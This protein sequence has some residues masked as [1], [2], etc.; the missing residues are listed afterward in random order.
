[1]VLPDC[2]FDL[3]SPLVIDAS[4]VINLNATGCAAQILAAIPNRIVVTD[5]VA[6][7]LEAGR[8]KGRTDAEQLAILVGSSHVDR[9]PLSPAAEEHFLNLVVGDGVATLDDG[10][11][12]TIAWAVSQSGIPVI[13]DK[14]AV[15]VCRRNF[16]TVVIGS[17]VDLLAQP[18]V[19]KQLGAIMLADSIFLALTV[20][21]MRVLDAIVFQSE[22]EKR[23]GQQLLVRCSGELGEQASVLMAIFL[24]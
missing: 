7:E 23:P 10:E 18:S 20:A 1:M 17:T 19:A 11:A 14:K 8:A 3:S 5:M 22:C 4:V 12:A 13:D 16:P 2:L 15:T 6:D 24:T 9:V 21:R